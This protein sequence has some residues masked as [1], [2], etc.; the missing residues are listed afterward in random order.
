[1]PVPTAYTEQSLM[2]YM[3]EALSG[4]GDVLGFTPPHAY[5]EA[6]NEV[7]LVYG[8]SDV[9]AVTGAS[10]IRKLRAI[11]RVEAWRKVMAA[12][13]GDYDFR[14]EDGASY[15]RS[16]VHAQAHKNYL[17]ALKEARELGVKAYQQVAFAQGSAKI[18]FGQGYYKGPETR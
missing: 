9:T 17:Q 3:H 11:A 13:A 5:N 18:D 15:N 14:R 16:Q 6:F 2:N 10:N 8:A 12:T 1:M 4:V 7:M